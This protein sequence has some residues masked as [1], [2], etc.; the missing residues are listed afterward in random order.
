MS[1][2]GSDGCGRGPVQSGLLLPLA[3][4][5][6]AADLPAVGGH[7]VRTG[8]E[9]LIGCR[10]LVACLHLL[11]EYLNTYNGTFIPSFNQRLNYIMNNAS[12]LLRFT[13]NSDTH[14]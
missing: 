12:Y 11:R 2:C 14:H 13:L 6:Y 7:Q 4:H 9:I 3:G 1:G 5:F 8:I 10:P